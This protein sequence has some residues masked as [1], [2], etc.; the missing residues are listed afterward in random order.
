MQSISYV[1]KYTIDKE[2]KSFYVKMLA[3]R[4]TQIKEKFR[5]SFIFNLF[6]V[7]IIYIH[8][9]SFIFFFFSLTIISYVL[10]IFL[11]FYPFK[12]FILFFCMW[13]ILFIITLI[14]FLN[15]FLFCIFF[16]IPF[17]NF[18]PLSIYFPIFERTLLRTFNIK[19]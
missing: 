11:F 1:Q 8:I 6:V 9:A 18:L 5:Q 19:I 16:F 10:L 13:L 15:N 4:Q 3:P 12:L 2:Y 7:I 14:I 17:F